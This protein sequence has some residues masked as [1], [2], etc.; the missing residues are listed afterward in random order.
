MICKSDSIPNALNNI[1][2]GISINC[3]DMV[4]NHTLSFLFLIVKICKLSEYSC[5]FEFI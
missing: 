1:N 2:N 4:T 5:F 3:D